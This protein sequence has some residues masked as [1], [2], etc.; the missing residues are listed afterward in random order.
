MVLAPAL[1]GVDKTNAINVIEGLGLG[2]LDLGS[3]PT[4]SISLNNTIATQS[5]VA[6][7][8]IEYET[9]ISISYYT[10]VATPTPT[11]TP[12]TPTPTPTTTWY[13]YYYGGPGDSY[14][15]TASTD[16][17]TCIGASVLCSTSGFPTEAQ[18]QASCSATPTPT[19]A[20]TVWYG[21]ACCNGSVITASSTGGESYVVDYLDQNC[22]TGTITNVTVVQGTSASPSYPSIDC[23]TTPTPTPTPTPVP[24]TTWYGAACCNGSVITAASSGGESYVV[25]ALDVNCLTGTVTN[26]VI[27]TSGYPSITCTTTPT[28]TPTPVTPTPTPTPTQVCGSGCMNCLDYGGEWNYA[29]GTCTYPTFTPTPTFSVFYF[30]ASPSPTPS[31]APFSVFYFWN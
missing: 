30:S 24:I 21:S 15:Y 28:P 11:P 9:I 2:Y 1:V 22:L 16:E 20:Y 17:S 12:S 31:P 6:G 4:S 26:M 29:T 8:L 5:V 27:S 7:T 23:T 13:C 18:A 3:V 14:P 25:D 19:P 10:Y